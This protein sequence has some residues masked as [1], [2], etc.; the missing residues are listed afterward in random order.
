MIG[1]DTIIF[2]MLLTPACSYC[3]LIEPNEIL[4]VL[5]YDNITCILPSSATDDTKNSWVR[6][7]HEITYLC[8]EHVSVKDSKPLL[9]K[10]VVSNSFDVMGVMG[11]SV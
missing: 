5:L 11:L 8:A 10:Y 3:E 7:G 6:V 2:P 4:S 1:L 9:I